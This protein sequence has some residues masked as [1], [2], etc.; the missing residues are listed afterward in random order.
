MIKQKNVKGHQKALRDEIRG[1]GGR[2]IRG[3]NTTEVGKEERDGWEGAALNQPTATAGLQ[4]DTNSQ[5]SPLH[6]APPHTRH[7]RQIIV[8][9][10]TRVWAST[11][12][13]ERE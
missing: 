5:P 1:E 13:V 10:A 12:R 8:R 11:T 2:E 7:H 9:P 3:P 4:S 6:I